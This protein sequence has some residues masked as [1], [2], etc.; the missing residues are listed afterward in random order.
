MADL[1]NTVSSWFGKLGK[2]PPS[3]EEHSRAPTSPEPQES[4]EPKEAQI[5]DSDLNALSDSKLSEFISQQSERAVIRHLQSLTDPEL[6]LRVIAHGVTD[7]P[8]L[9]R[10]ARSELSKKLKRAAEKKLR[11]TGSGGMELRL[12]KLGRLNDQMEA[13]LR[14]PDW[15]GAPEL[16]AVVFAPHVI[17]TP[18]DESNSQYKDFQLLR[19]RLKNSVDEYEKTCAEMEEICNQ[20]ESPRSLSKSALTQLQSRWKDLE[21]KYSF[22]KTFTTPEK[23]SHLVQLRA[24]PHQPNIAPPTPAAP[25][26]VTPEPTARPQPVAEDPEKARKAEESRKSRLQAVENL[27]KNLADVADHL[28]HRQAGARLKEL[29]N[30]ATALRRWKKEYPAQLDEA[31]AL[32]KSLSSKRTEAVDEAKWDSWARTDLAI[33]IQNELEKTIGE[34]EAEQDPESALKNSAGL[35]QRLHDYAKEMRALGSL[36]RS[37]DHKIWETFKSLSDRGWVICERMR[38]LALEKLKGTLTEH[39]SKPIDFTAPA[40]TSTRATLQLKLTAFDPQV[41]TQIKELQTLWREIGSKSSKANQESEI[42]FTKLFELYFRQL[43]L[44]LGQQKR[45]E[46]SAVEKKQELLREMKIACEGKSPLLARTRAARSLEERWKS[47]PLPGSV[48]AEMG[49]EFEGYLSRLN[50][51]LSEEIEKHV[52]AASALQARAETV[53]NSILAKNGTNLSQA[54]KSVTGLAS[55]LSALE[56]QLAQFGSTDSRFREFALRLQALF[57]ECKAAASKE[58]TERARERNQILLE[59]EEMVGAEITDGSRARFEELKPLWKKAGVLGQ[60]QDQ[61]F[62]LLFEN[63]N[64]CYAG[65]AD[66]KAQPPEPAQN[67]KALKIQKELIFSLEALTR[68]QETKIESCPLPFADEERMKATGEVM[69][70]GL[71]YKQILS[72]DPQGGTLKEVK[73]IMEQWS[74]LRIAESDVQAGYWKYYLNRVHALL[75]VRLE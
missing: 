36:E 48:A 25:L 21:E 29:Q 50:A 39:V 44:H 55:E 59:A 45:V 2:K 51:E 60:N 17:E 11:E 16:L 71:K 70:F 6:Q 9:K 28:S 47:S 67:E 40:L 12:Q 57:Q 52:A 5:P 53:L 8:T 22:P 38:L 75:D 20:L 42:V 46:L 56:S 41:S 10:I 33:R 31:E 69:K 26:T 14:N 72:L 63:L 54:L 24:L 30:E 64:R 68:L 4:H 3:A 37:K 7:E 73:K 18:I 61:I 35:T 58:I 49:A 15:L 13:F 34:L 23:F 74:K 66:S 62:E 27:L 32:I 65:R 19:N 1:L 43:N